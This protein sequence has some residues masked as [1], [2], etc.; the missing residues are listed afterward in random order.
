MISPF[1]YQEKVCLMETPADAPCV[2]QIGVKSGYK[3]R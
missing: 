2:P 1:I 3:N